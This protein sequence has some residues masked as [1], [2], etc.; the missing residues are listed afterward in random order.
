[1]KKH[2]LL[3]GISLS[4]LT[5]L[6][7]VVIHNL[8]GF[9]ASSLVLLLILVISSYALTMWDPIVPVKIH[10]NGTYISWSFMNVPLSIIFITFFLIIPVA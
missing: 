7:L 9:V 3:K 1:M 6:I 2:K 10:E 5:F 8:L 4:A